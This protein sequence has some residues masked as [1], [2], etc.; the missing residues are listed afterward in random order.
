VYWCMI[1]TSSGWSRRDGDIVMR[2]G[3]RGRTCVSGKKFIS[4]R[5][6][7]GQELFQKSFRCGGHELYT[8]YSMY[9]FLTRNHCLTG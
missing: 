4:S 9:H 8:D 5:G 2:S 7:R 6:K 3:G 1:K